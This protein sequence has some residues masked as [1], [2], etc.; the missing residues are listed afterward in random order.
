MSKTQTL[1][2][3]YNA[4]TPVDPRVLETMLPFF[5][6]Q[7]GNSVSVTHPFGW[8]AEKA[9]EKARG[10]VA[11][12]LHCEPQEIV[13]TSGATESNN[14]AIEGLIESIRME[15]GSGARIHLLI[16]P[17]EHNSVLQAAK[18]AQALFGAEVDYL[19]VNSYGQVIVEGLPSL[20]KPHT[21]LLAAMWVNNEL[22]SVNPVRE[23]AE[24]CHSHRIYYL[25]DA[26]QA[27]GKV[28]VDLGKTPVDLL[29]FSAHKLGGPK[30][31][32]L[33][34]MRSRNPR[35]ELPC[36]IAG[37]GHERGHRSG[38]LNTPAIVGMGKC[39]ELALLE[40]TA[41]QARIRGLRDLMWQRISAE[42]SGVRMNGHPTQR[43]AN[44]LHVT[45]TD[46]VLPITLR[47][48]AASRGSACLS[49][50]TSTSHVLKAL[51]WTEADATQSLR[52]SLGRPTTE[53]EVFEAVSL[54]KA[55]LRPKAAKFQ[56][57]SI[58]FKAP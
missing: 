2:F 3:D 12:L 53:A 58:S 36:L 54:L 16:S 14:W 50:K 15:E 57:N 43:S 39:C 35:I 8:E 24:F 5:S 19:P 7:F 25:C 6:E 18:R 52:L 51:G 47:G 49:G 55:Q 1:Y 42:I 44:N 13:F 27:V 4:T 20:I 23:I 29:S 17:V 45:F 37:G 48:L 9:V 21:R 28:P 10:Q 22:G 34:Y 30:G 56:V 31:I 32:G 40:G 26:T 38:T 11:A 41:E 33:L 46:F